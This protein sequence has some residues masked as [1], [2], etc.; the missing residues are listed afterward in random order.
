LAKKAKTGAGKKK[1]GKSKV[2]GAK[3]KTTSTVHALALR[4]PLDPLQVQTIVIANTPNHPGGG[5]DP[6]TLLQQLGVVDDESQAKVAAG[7]QKDLNQLGWHIK[8]AD[9]ESAPT[10]SVAECRDSVLQNAF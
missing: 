5:V 2:S 3:A 9:I 4:Q 10:N 6:D 8:Q 7:V 1:A